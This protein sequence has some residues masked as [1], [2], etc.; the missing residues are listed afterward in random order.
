MRSLSNFLELPAKSLTNVIRGQ[1][2]PIDKNNHAINPMEWVCMALPSNPKD[3]YY[4][5]Y[6]KNGI[7]LTR[8]SQRRQAY[9]P[10]QLQDEVPVY[11]PYERGDW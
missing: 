7:D 9:I 11:T 3:L 8:E 10:W 2:K 4:G 1:D 6:D 5:V